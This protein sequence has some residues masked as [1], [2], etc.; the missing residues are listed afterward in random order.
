[1]RQITQE[2]FEDYM[3][4]LR[5]AIEA[6]LR[7]AGKLFHEMKVDDSQVIRK[8]AA[9]FVT[10]VDYMVQDFIIRNLNKILPESNIIS[11]E[12]KK[13]NY[14]F[15]RPTWILDPVDGTTNFMYGYRH[16]AISLLLVAEQKPAL[17]FI[18]NPYTDEMFYAEAGN[19]AWLNGS[20]ITV[21]CHKTLEDSLIAFGTTPYDRSKAD[22]TFETVK[23]IYLQCRD[24][25]RSGSAALDIAYV[26]CGRIDGFFEYCLQPWDYAAGIL[27]L[28]EA[29]GRITN[30][31]GGELNAL[32]PDSVLATNKLI[33]ATMLEAVGQ[34]S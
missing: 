20:K 31:K 5:Q 12:S 26:A 3:H 32:S 15:D 9:N 2:R 13:N 22:V 8:G 34:H 33:H 19:G 6:S 18:Y 14:S 11:E 30:F 25:R 24:I 23:H 21:S 10:Q 4:Y 27:I 1:M 16:S 17:S 28:Q 7:E 29:G